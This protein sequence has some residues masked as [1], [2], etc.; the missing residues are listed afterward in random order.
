MPEYSWLLKENLDFDGIQKRVDA[1]AMLGVPYGD[2]VR[3]GR[4][5]DMAREQAKLIAADLVKQGGYSGLES[6]KIIA[7]VAYL[8]RLGTD[9]TAPPP[10]TQPAPTARE[11]ATQGQGS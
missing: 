6:K 8:Q 3:E 11:S 7:L 1:M 5:P 10:A 9:L 4:A 2:A